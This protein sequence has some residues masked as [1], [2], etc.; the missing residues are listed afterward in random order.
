MKSEPQASTPR[1]SKTQDKGSGSSVNSTITSAVNGTSKR[2]RA[3]SRSDAED[4]PEPSPAASINST[5]SNRSTR[6]AHSLLS[7]DSGKKCTK[8]KRSRMTNDRKLDLSRAEDDWLED[9]DD[10][11]PVSHSKTSKLTKGND[12]NHSKYNMKT[13]APPTVTP[14]RSGGGHL[15]LSGARSGGV[16]VTS[17]T[18]TN[19]VGSASSGGS[20]AQ[21]GKSRTRNSVPDCSLRNLPFSVQSSAHKGS[22]TSKLAFDS[23]HKKRKL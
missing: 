8:S 19:N 23:S 20:S 12:A 16:A 18:R 4:R 11:E 2:R 22:S 17:A 3:D 6:S 9:S 5:R 7:T 14:S 13:G 15:M 21:R 10:D 1:S